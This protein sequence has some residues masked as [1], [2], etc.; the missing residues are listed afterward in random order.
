LSHTSSPFCYGDFG[1][2]GL[3]NYL[4]GLTLNWNPLSLSLPR[5]RITGMSHQQPGSD[6]DLSGFQHSELWFNSLFYQILT[7]EQLFL[8]YS[9]GHWA[10]A[11]FNLL[12]FAL[13]TNERA[14]IGTHIY[15]TSRP[16][17]SFLPQGHGCCRFLGRTPKSA[18]RKRPEV[19]YRPGELWA[20]C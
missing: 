12:K 17:Y 14:R 1:D 10:S 16:P 20:H 18:C 13:S 19:R 4:P 7:K 3:M 5:A 9:W 8:F 2:G 11:Q 15:V 6:S